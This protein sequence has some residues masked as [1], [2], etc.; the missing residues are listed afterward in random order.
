MEESDSLR[1]NFADLAL[2]ALGAGKA[3]KPHC[4]CVF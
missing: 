2:R 1:S 4:V 3:A